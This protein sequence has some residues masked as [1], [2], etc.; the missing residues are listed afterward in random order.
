MKNNVFLSVIF[1]TAI[2]GTLT[3]CTFGHIRGNGKIIS[4]ERNAEDFTDVVLDGVGKVN[5]HTSENYKVVVTTDSNIQ[6]IIEINTHGQRLYIDENCK[7]G[8]NPTKLTID[9]YMPEVKNVKLN[10]VGKIKIADGKTSDLA[11]DLC[12]VGDIE[13]HYYEVQNVDISISGTGDVKTLVTGTLKGD[14]SGVGTI[15]YKG[16]PE[17]QKS[18]TG[19]GNVKPL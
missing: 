9:V 12:G 5:I 8:F 18:V 10:G 14:I 15:F 3:C 16:K 1:A 2:V 7:W 17:I 6:D 19:V 11:I 4:Q 13:A